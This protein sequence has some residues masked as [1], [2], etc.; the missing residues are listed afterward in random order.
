MKM[1]ELILDDGDEFGVNAMSLVERPAIGEHFVAFNEQGH[2]EIEF[3][4]ADKE[5]QILLGAALIP[6]LPVY[7]K[8]EDGSEG[9]VYLSKETVRQVAHRYLRLGLQ[10]ESTL[11]HE[12][13]IDGCTV[14]EAWVKEGEHDKSMNYGL[15]YPDGSWVIAMEASDEMWS[16]HVKTG[17]VKGFSIEA[18]FLDKMKA[19]ETNDDFMSELEE[20]V[21]S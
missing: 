10:G 16:E 21:K 13:K 12:R 15:D 4:A 17:K 19:R 6:N 5:R 20:L 7:R 11:E 1:I 3:K 2:R 9:Y 14:V 18:K 8:F